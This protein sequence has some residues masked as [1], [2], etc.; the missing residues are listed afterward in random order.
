MSKILVLHGPSLNLLGQRE[1]QVIAQ[2]GS[3]VAAARPQLER[4][5]GDILVRWAVLR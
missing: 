1:P 3:E 4:G 5:L 2:V